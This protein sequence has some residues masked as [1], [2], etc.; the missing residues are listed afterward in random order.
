MSSTCPK[1]LKI[2][3]PTAKRIR[4]YRIAYSF[5]GRIRRWRTDPAPPWL[6][7]RIKKFKLSEIFCMTPFVVL[8]RRLPLIDLDL[9]EAVAPQGK[10]CNPP[11]S[12]V[13]KASAEGSSQ[14]DYGVVSPMRF[15]G[16]DLPGE[17]SLKMPRDMINTYLY[18]RARRLDHI[19]RCPFDY[20]RRPFSQG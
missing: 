14:Q 6:G 13:T 16:G 2:I 18:F 15:Q 10:G 7:W 8:C 4:W 11:P 12:L 1:K 20:R 3:F 9:T 17:P 19:R 5:E